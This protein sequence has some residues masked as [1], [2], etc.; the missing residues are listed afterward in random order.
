MEIKP[1]ITMGRRRLS[2]LAIDRNGL[3]ARAI[4]NGDGTVTVNWS[5]YNLTAI[6]PSGTWTVER[7]ADRVNWSTIATGID[8][9]TLTGT[10][11]GSDG[12]LLG[13][14]NYFRVKAKDSGAVLL[15]TSNIAQATTPEPWELPNVITYYDWEPES[16]ETMAGI[17]YDAASSQYHTSPHIS[18]LDGAS[19]MTIEFWRGPQYSY[20]AS[21]EQGFIGQGG[22]ALGGYSAGSGFVLS[23]YDYEWNGLTLLTNVSNSTYKRAAYN[24]GSNATSHL[25]TFDN[26][27]VR[28]WLDG[29]EVTLTS[30]DLASTLPSGSSL[31]R[32][33][34]GY[35]YGNYTWHCARIWNRALTAS[36]ALALTQNRKTPVLYADL[37]DASAGITTDLLRNWETAKT[38][39]D[40][41]GAVLT[42]V[43]SPTT[44]TVVYQRTCRASGK[45]LSGKLGDGPVRVA[46]VFKTGKYAGWNSSI[47]AAEAWVSHAALDGEAAPVPYTTTSGG[48]LT[49]V[50]PSAVPTGINEIFGYSLYSNDVSDYQMPGVLYIGVITAQRWAYRLRSDSAGFDASY[51]AN[52]APSA[53]TA[54]IVTWTYAPG[55]VECYI[56]GVDS[57]ATSA[58]PAAAI[59]GFDEMDDQQKHSSSFSGGY[60]WRGY[61]GATIRFNDVPD[62]ALLEQLK[63]YLQT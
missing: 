38:T 36:E 26:G 47:D 18:E 35:R 24:G 23:S 2:A 13:A 30:N 8:D 21:N 12:V 10:Y 53:N 34:S 44:E 60:S 62:S 57:S 58:F 28:M 3:T 41:S 7:S 50:K 45:V 9:A 33:G 17:R 20:S 1:G 52:S 42:P 11:D 46:D 63:A 16:T 25:M 61:E 27:T 39:C 15:A 59:Y 14:A 56:N 55:N 40:V 43:N 29:V 6:D 54:Y 19:A 51:Y 4:D 5:G 32:I 22:A 48:I 31:L 49:Q 37:E